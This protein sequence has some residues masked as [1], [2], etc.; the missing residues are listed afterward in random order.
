[1]K[2]TIKKKTNPRSYVHALGFLYP[3]I[4]DSDDVNPLDFRSLVEN[5]QSEF[6]EPSRQ[7]HFIKG[8]G[9]KRYASGSRHLSPEGL[10]WFAGPIKWNDFSEWTLNN[11]H[12]VFRTEQDRT[13]ARV[14]IGK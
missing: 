1:M 8:R 7:W 2:Y 5:L 10:R 11:R 3:I 9:L 13:W 4:L 12:I 6:G 14:L